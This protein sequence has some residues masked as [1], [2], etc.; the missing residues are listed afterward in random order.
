MVHRSLWNQ[1]GHVDQ[2]WITLIA[3]IIKA[4]KEHE[5]K[6]KIFEQYFGSKR[7]WDGADILDKIRWKWRR[8]WWG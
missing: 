8:G 1:I 2:Y 6:Q 4:N 5:Y 3:R 7:I